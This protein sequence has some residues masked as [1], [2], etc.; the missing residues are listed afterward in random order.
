[1]LALAP[2]A[3]WLLRLAALL[4]G[5]ASAAG[6]VAWRWRLSGRDAER[7]LMLAE[8][9]LPALRATPAARRPV[10]HRLGAER[11]ADLVR[12]AA[13]EDPSDDAGAALAEALAESARWQPKS[14]PITGH[15]VL[16]LGVPAGP[17]VGQVLAQVEDWWIA[18]DFRPD[19]AACLAKARAFLHDPGHAA[20][21][22]SP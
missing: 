12:L 11:Y 22:P 19:H 13:A 5:Q 3:D 20:T 4:R 8:H 17:V 1:L 7:L 15:D 2:E 9:P 21:P 18:Q 10:L 16:G 6:E 14:L